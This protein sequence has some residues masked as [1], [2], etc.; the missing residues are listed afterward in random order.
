MKII[1]NWRRAWRMASMQIAG[2]AVVFGTLP[3]DAQAAMLDMVGVP[4]TRVPAI[5]GL[6]FMA[7][8]LLAQQKVGSGD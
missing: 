1:P 7:G 6:L 5:L 3:A 8:R 4:P 2:L